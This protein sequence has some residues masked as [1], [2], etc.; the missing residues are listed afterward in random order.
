MLDGQ[1]NKGT[2][3]CDARAR[4]RFDWT[5]LRPF[6]DKVMSPQGSLG[7]GTF[8]A[9]TMP[10]LPQIPPGIPDGEKIRDCIPQHDRFE[11]CASGSDLD[12]QRSSFHLN[13]PLTDDLPE[14]KGEEGSGAWDR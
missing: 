1:E 2:D 3:A 5:R 13:T 4:C 8:F 10:M 9:Q 7:A 6:C 14:K 11:C 12:R